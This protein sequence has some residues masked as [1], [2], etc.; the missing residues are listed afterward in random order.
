[1]LVQ[2]AADYTQ[3]LLDHAMIGYFTSQCPLLDDI[4]EWVQHKFAFLRGWKVPLVKFVGKI[5]FQIMF[6]DP[7]HCQQA[8]SY[9]PWKYNKFVYFFAYEPEFNVNTGH[10]TKLPVWVEITY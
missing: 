2:E 8:L 4:Y 7:L 1:M 9:H 10:Y 5:F 3:Y 6:E